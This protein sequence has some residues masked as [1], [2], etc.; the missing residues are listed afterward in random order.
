MGIIWNWKYEMHSQPLNSLPTPAKP[1]T[2]HGQNTI[3]LARRAAAIDSS[4]F[5]S[6]CEKSLSRVGSA[7]DKRACAESRQVVARSREAAA[8]DGQQVAAITRL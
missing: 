8:A 2:D 6:W 3:D 1:L 4:A 7:G 5:A